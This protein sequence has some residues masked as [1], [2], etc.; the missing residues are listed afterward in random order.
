MIGTE[1]PYFAT[2]PSP[3]PVLHFMAQY[4]FTAEEAAMVGDRE[5]DLGSARNAGIQ[6]IHLQCVAVPE[7]LDCNWEITDLWQILDML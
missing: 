6:T 2:K 4:G 7:K 1:S 3:A 5:C